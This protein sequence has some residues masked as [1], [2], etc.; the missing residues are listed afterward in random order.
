MLETIDG[1]RRF[2]SS[3]FAYPLGQLTRDRPVAFKVRS[4]QTAKARLAV[5]QVP[6]LLGFEVD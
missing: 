5:E 4:A 3:P 2:Q 6:E 1:L